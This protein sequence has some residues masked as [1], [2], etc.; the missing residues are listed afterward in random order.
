MT[1]EPGSASVMNEERTG[2]SL[3]QIQCIHKQ[4]NLMKIITYI[5]Q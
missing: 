3:W 1:K 2:K 4:L 5:L